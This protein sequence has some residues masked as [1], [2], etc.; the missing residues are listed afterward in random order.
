M[1]YS[2]RGCRTD[3]V[4]GKHQIP[5]L[6]TIAGRANLLHYPPAQLRTDRRHRLQFGQRP[7]RQGRC[8]PCHRH[9]L[10]GFHHR[11]VDGVFARRAVHRL[12]AARHDAGKHMSLP[13]VGDARLG[14]SALDGGLRL[15][16]A[17]S[18]WT[19][20]ARAQAEWNDY[21]A[22][23]V[24]RRPRPNG[25]SYAQAIGA[26]NAPATSATA[27]S[28][29]PAACRPKSRP[30]GARFRLG[31]VDVEFGFSCMGYEIAGGWGARIAPARTRAR[32]GHH[33]LCRRRL[34]S[35]DEFR[36]LFLG[37]DRREADR[38]GLDNG[39]FAV[40]NKLQN[41]TGNDSFNNLIARL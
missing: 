31:T 6:E 12:N 41:N 36:H 29:R 40:I 20:V 37:S 21:V 34:L 33:R 7:R 15:S 26:V 30:I 18:D 25:R 32:A 13:V 23:N 3:A 4:C 5:V 19:G 22:D 24:A 27:L 10:A 17:G 14:A 16:G 28:R 8:H 39:G 2:R 1:Q 9:P 38:P 35:A 11:L